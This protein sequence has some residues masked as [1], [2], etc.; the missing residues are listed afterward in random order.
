MNM[1][2]HG[3]NRTPIAKLKVFTTT[4]ER[5]VFPSIPSR[6]HQHAT[7]YDKKH[8]K[9]TENCFRRRLTDEV[10][11]GLAT[12]LLIWLVSDFAFAGICFGKHG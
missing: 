6:Q 5:N 4:H 7:T 12:F 10:G 8:A 2:T 3:K 9:K 1:P 11:L